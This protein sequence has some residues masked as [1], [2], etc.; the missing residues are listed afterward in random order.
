MISRDFFI[1]KTERIV[2][3]PE[4]DHGWVVDENKF[5]SLSTFV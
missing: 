1:M 3:L 5:L 4:I 2:F